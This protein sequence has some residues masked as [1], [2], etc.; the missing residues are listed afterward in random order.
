VSAGVKPNP[1]NYK[2]EKAPDGSWTIFDVP[3][4]SAHERTLSNGKVWKCDAGWLGGALAAAKVRHAEGYFH[5][6][7]VRHHALGTPGQDDSEVVAAGHVRFS[8]LGELRI[9]GKPTATLFADLVGVPES[10]YLEIKAGRLSYRSAEILD[11]SSGEIDSLA[12]L[13]HEVPFFRYPLLRVADGVETTTTRPAVASA[14]L[15]FSAAGSARSVLFRYS[16]SYSMDPKENEPET[17][18]DDDGLPNVEV[19]AAAPD[20]LS[21]LKEGLMGLLAM[22]EKAGES[23]EAPAQDE[24]PAELSSAPAPAPAPAAPAAAPIAA[25]AI[26]DAQNAGKFDALAGRVAQMETALKAAELATRVA[27]FGAQLREE[28]FTGAQV[29]K[30][31]ATTAQSGEAAGLAYAQALRDNGPTPPPSTWTGETRTDAFD[32]PEV[33][34]YSA[35][36]PEVL[37]YARDL[38]RSHKAT[39]STLPLATYI[40]NLIDQE[41]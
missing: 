23:E 3:V 5:P 29:A 22:L 28:G 11:T 6:A 38:A 36:G 4:F 26:A 8:R 19:K 16:E 25:Q 15:A 34:A 21:Q 18:S 32:A 20:M 10:V 14:A 30:F 33:A 17:S 13:D 37:A 27:T 7:H 9:G 41:A 2:A 40:S 35:K 1:T 31:E 39:R 24:G 12:F